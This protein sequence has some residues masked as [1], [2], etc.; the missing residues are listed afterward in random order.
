[1][2]TFRPYSLRHSDL[3]YEDILPEIREQIIELII[4]TLGSCSS[5]YDMALY[6]YH[7]SH[8]D[9]VYRRIC[10]TLR[11]EYGL[12]SLYAH[13]TSYLDEISN[14]LLK[15]DDKRKHIDII[16]L[17]FKYIDTYLRNYDVTPGLEPDKAISELNNIFH[18]NNLKYRF[19]NGRIV[20]LRRIKR[21][22][23][24]RYYLYSPGEYGFVEYDLMEAYNRLIFNDFT[25]VVSEC[26]SVF[27][28]VLIKI[29]EKKNIIYQET[30]NLSAL[31][32]NLVTSGV[33]SAE[34]EHKFS[35][36]SNV[37][38]SEVFSPT[39]K[40]KPHHHHVMMLR[41][42]E[43]LACSIYYLTERTIFFLTQRAEENDD[44]P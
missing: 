17:A 10:K 34:D 8:S 40:E 21:L 31:I 15:T 16:E 20:R 3:L 6:C 42:S 12:F 29:H 5:F 2:H 19:E 9:E 13:S 33:I 41:I 23:S 24:I 38:E 18:E 11:K 4:N 35:F 14:L 36:L 1:M 22:K 27:K 32:A 26:Y 7:N 28:S 39:A 30:D 44:R 43:E 25:C 37:L